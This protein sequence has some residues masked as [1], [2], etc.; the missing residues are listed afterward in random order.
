MDK[1]TLSNYGWIVICVLVLAVMIA[2]ATPFG[3]FISTAVENT[4]NG[5]FET[6]ASALEVALDSLGVVPTVEDLQ[7]RYKFQYYSTLRATTD[8]SAKIP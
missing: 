3:E 1:E 6:N 7:A 2:L 8:T 5:L 4:A